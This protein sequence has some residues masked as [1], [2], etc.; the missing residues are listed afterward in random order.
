MSSWSVMHAE[1]LLLL[2]LSRLQRSKL[3]LQCGVQAQSAHW[4]A[5]DVH[6]ASFCMGAVLQVCALNS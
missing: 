5:E 4:D 3:H 1:K 6:A 2:L